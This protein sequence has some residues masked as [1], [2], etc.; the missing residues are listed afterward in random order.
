MRFIIGVDTEYHLRARQLDDGGELW[1]RQRCRDRLWHSSELPGRAERDDPVDGVGQSD[2]DHVA[3]TH[4]EPGEFSGQPAAQDLQLGSG[5]RL[6]GARDRWSTRSFV[7]QDL[8]PTRKGHHGHVSSDLANLALHQPSRGKTR[9]SRPSTEHDNSRPASRHSA[10]E[11]SS[12]SAGEALARTT[13]PLH[14]SDTSRLP[15]K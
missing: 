13:A 6:P 2:G 7:G 12:I 10:K 8:Q 4:A 14:S 15:P 9:M 5:Q 1:L 3:V 11:G